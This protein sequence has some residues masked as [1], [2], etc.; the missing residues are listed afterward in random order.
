MYHEDQLFDRGDRPIEKRCVQEGQQLRC[1]NLIETYNKGKT[2]Y[3]A[4]DRKIYSDVKN[5]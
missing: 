1:I 2:K 3:T 5:F 4:E